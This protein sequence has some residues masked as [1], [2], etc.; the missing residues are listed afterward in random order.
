MDFHPRD[1]IAYSAQSAPHDA[2][3]PSGQRLVTFDCM[4]RIDLDL[5]ADLLPDCLIKYVSYA[6][7]L[8]LSRYAPWA[9]E[10]LRRSCQAQTSHLRGSWNSATSRHLLLTARR[11]HRQVIGSDVDSDGHKN[12]DKA[13][14]EAPIMMRTPPV[15][16]LAMAMMS[17]AHRM[18]LFGIVHHAGLQKERSKLRWD[19][20]VQAKI[21]GSRFAGCPYPT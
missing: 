7:T 6:Y 10:R 3:D 20:A 19:A 4:V 1:V 12:G 5:H 15:R 11:N 17:L 21:M 13:E 14:P 8:P 18:Q 9:L 16:S 2:P